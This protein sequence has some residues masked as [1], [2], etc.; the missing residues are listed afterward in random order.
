MGGGTG[1]AE[2]KGMFSALKRF[3]FGRITI[4]LLLV[5][6]VG[7]AHFAEIHY[8]S[9]KQYGVK[10]AYSL[11]GTWEFYNGSLS[12]AEAEHIPFPDRVEVPKL[13][14]ENIRNKLGDEFW[15]R[16]RFSLPADLRDED[17]T[18]SIGSVKGRNDVYFNGH[19]VGSGGVSGYGVYKIPSEF[20]TTAVS[21]ILVKVLKSETPFQG[22]VHFLPVEIGKSEGFT[23][24][25]PRYYFDLG[26]RPLLEGS[27][28]LF[29]FILF[30]L[31]VLAMP[32]RREYF[33]FSIYALLSSLAAISASR[34]FPFYNDFYVRNA[35]QFVLH[36]TSFCLVPL[37]SVQFIREVNS[38]RFYAL[39]YG[40][41]VAAVF[42]LASLITA[43]EARLGVFRMAAG[44]VPLLAI[45]PASALTAW[46]AS[47]LPGELVIRR[48]QLWLM[49]GSLLLGSLS[50]STTANSM[51]RFDAFLIR[52][53]LDLTIFLGLAAAMTLDFRVQHFRALGAG[54]IIPKWFNGHVSSGVSEASLDIPM[55][56]LA[57]DTVGYTKLLASLD[58]KKKN[59]LHQEIREA[60]QGLP[61]RFG[62][63][64]LTDRGDGAL[65]GWDLPI[66]PSDGELQRK[67]EGACAFLRSFARGQFGMQFRMGFAAGNVTAEMRNGQFSFLG[68]ALNAACRLETIA[69]PGVPLLDVS[70]VHLFE[71][72][73][74]SDWIEVEIK[75]VVYRGRA[76][77]NAA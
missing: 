37:L 21:T 38:R 68:Q 44:W 56:C 45:L 25:L 72:H 70:V 10:G 64:K 51:F 4:L 65:F 59:A 19:Y 35:I 46:Q 20:R 53:L 42:F 28:K 27:L 6:V 2:E 15:Y 61:A 36:T 43:G 77:K 48:S 54:K 33:S 11:S 24:L 3:G 16:H 47:R 31:L 50:W 71:G 76:L 14:P 40:A 41:S 67:V 5:S 12:R 23:E 55:L 39:L 69:E 18:L 66:N 9:R 34:F 13:L 73:C 60:M 58:N 52:E 17:L 8:T 63:Q 62:A 32:D 74:E 75:G 1:L 22:I 7:M 49:A 30:G 57:V 29:F 26:V